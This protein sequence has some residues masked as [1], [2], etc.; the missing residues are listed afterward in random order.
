MISVEYQ[1]SSFTEWVMSSVADARPAVVSLVECFAKIEDPRVKRSRL[2]SLE[3]ILVLAVLAVIAG[4]EGWEDIED[5]GKHKLLL[6]RRF[7]MFK[8][9]VP[10]HDTISRVFRALKPGVF[11]AAFMT[12]V[13]TVHSEL[14]FKQI[15][16]D[17][18]SLRRSHDHASLKKMLH[19]VSAWSVENHLVL[20]EL[21]VDEKSNEITAIPQLL[22]Q[23]E[24]EGAIVTI[25]AM[26]CQKE[27][28][29]KITDGGGEY[30]LGA[31]DNHPKLCG[32]ITEHFTAAH[33]ADFKGF[34]VR[35]Y[36]TDENGHGRT[37]TRHYYQS[38][39]PDSM[40]EQTDQWS[41]M[42]TICQ[43]VNLSERD[44]KE[45]SE[46]RYYISSLPLGVKRF[47]VASRGHWGIENSLHWV[48]DM[49]F[50]EDQSRIRKDH[51]AENF[52]LLRRFAIGIIKQDSSKGSVRRKRKKAA[53]DDSFLLTLLKS[54]T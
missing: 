51:G 26:G 19:S 1:E 46:V 24:L 3:E 16:I 44:G 42:K 9:G 17:G 22:D 7:L 35:H 20:G 37:E 36:Q 30:V 15:A 8:N 48:L 41:K 53:W 6:L 23:L 11:Q 38:S 27:I 13:Q 52:G 43:V 4:A 32:A 18:K 5:Y 47:A 21:A 25:D 49:T 14:G 39:I 33:E 29:E 34:A 28:A 2:H 40:R 50:N 10:S 31:K 12:W 54:M 45:T